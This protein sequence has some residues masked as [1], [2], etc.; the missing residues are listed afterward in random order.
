[1]ASGILI[2]L[3]AFMAKFTFTSTVIAALVYLSYGIARIFS[4]AI[5]GMPTGSIVAA[6]ALELII[7]L[8]GV[9]ALLRYRENE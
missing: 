4:M 9:F 3:G 5:D 2:I 6:T 1:M 8:A 7:G